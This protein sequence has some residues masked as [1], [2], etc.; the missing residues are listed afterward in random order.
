MVEVFI[1][2]SCLGNPGSIGIGYRI[3]RQ[4]NVLE[5]KG[6][7]LGQGTNNTAEYLALICALVAV[8]GRGE[9][10]CRVYSDSELLCQQIRGAYRVRNKNILP[11]FTLAKHA[12]AQMEEFSIRHIPRERNAAADKLA[13]EAASALQTRYR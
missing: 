1:D 7:G 4:E 8:A 11:L 2:G 13:R 5:E 12:I 9:K 6:I 10:Q 3:C